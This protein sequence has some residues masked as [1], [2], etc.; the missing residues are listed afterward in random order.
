MDL[1]VCLFF[2]PHVRFELRGF[3]FPA[4][5]H[6]PARLELPPCEAGLVAHARKAGGLVVDCGGDIPD[7]LSRPVQDW[8]M[9]HPSDYACAIS[10]SLM[11]W[12]DALSWVRAATIRWLQHSAFILR[13]F[14]F[15]GPERFERLTWPVR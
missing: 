14:V 2:D 13:G 7:C 6:N 5:M 9:G 12:G 1:A 10:S 4:R 15:S 11:F 8:R 3:S